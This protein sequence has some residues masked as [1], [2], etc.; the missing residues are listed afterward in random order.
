M[1]LEADLHTVLSGVC[2]RVYPD[3]A[4]NKTTKPYITWSQVGG[5]V[6]KPLANELASKRNARIQ[7]NVWS[8]TRAEAVTLMLACE[9]ALIESTL[10]VATQNGAAVASYSE[11][12][13]TRGMFQLFSVW[14]D[15]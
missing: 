8:K 14:A 6:L 4:P 15:R 1:S 12:D 13:D 5:N 10:F 3:V 9:Q 11:D 2:P 7:V